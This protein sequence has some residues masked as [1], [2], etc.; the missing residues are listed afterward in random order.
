M[1]NQSYIIIYIL[2]MIVLML[3]GFYV[4][5]SRKKLDE[6]HGMMIGMTF[7]MFAGLL[8][9]TLYLIPTGNFLNGVI[10]G[11]VVGLL[12]GFP[13]GKIGGHLGIVEGVIAGPM[14]GMMGA[15]LGQMIR[16]F[17]IEVFIPFFMLIFL[18]TMLGIVYAISCGVACCNTNNK[19]LKKPKLSKQT[20]GI[21]LI[22][23]IIIL[24]VSVTLSFSNDT[25]ELKLP[26]YLAD[27]AKQESKE[28]VIKEG[29]QEINLRITSLG[30]KPNII[31]AKKGIPLKINIDA[32]D[33]AGCSR[34]IVFPDFN[35]NK[36]I[37]SEGTFIQIA[38]EKEGTYKF[39]CSMDMVRGNLIIQ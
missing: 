15:M 9:S 30:Y 39:R 16:P 25:K 32:D 38:P 21:G 37:P 22:I 2:S 28:A 18:I 7:G 13:F 35:I 27:A 8:T 4:Y 14:G 29:Y 19:I 31:V 1:Q 6:M 10:I 3:V 11:S 23:T 34:E 20:I 26:K 5:K 24:I 12:F 36:I 33:N 17:N